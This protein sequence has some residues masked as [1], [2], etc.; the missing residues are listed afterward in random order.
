MRDIRRFVPFLLVPLGLLAVS[1]LLQGGSPAFAEDKPT[2]PAAD[3][4]MGEDAPVAADPDDEE[5]DA[6]PAL[7]E[8]VKIAIKKGVQWLKNNQMSD[9]GWG[10]IEGTHAYGGGKNTNAYKHPAGAAALALYTLLKCKVPMDDPVIR[11]GFKFLKDKYPKPGS[12]YE[13]SMMLLAVTAT[14]DPFKRFSASTAS[15]EAQKVKLTGEW[16]AWATSLKD[17]LLTKRK[18]RQGW[19]YNVEQSGKGSASS[20]PGGDQDLSSTQLA[21]LALLAAERCNVKVDSKVW[22][23]IADFSIKQQQDDGPEWERAVYDRKSQA[24][25]K[26]DPTSGGGDYAKPKPGDAKSPK[27]RARGFAYIKSDK[28]EPDEGQATGGMTACGVGNIQMCRYIL[29]KRKEVA[30]EPKDADALQRV[31]DGCAWLDQNWSPASNPGKKKENVYHIYYM[32]CV[33]RAFDLI[34]NQR[35]GGHMWYVEMA[36]QLCGMQRDKGFWNS[37]STHK[38]EEVLDT[39]FALLVLKQ[40][41]RGGIP[42]GSVTNPGDEPPADNRGK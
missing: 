9:G 34:G 4:A 10:N 37:D 21:T 14:A 23:D 22:M 39:C 29:M 38:P 15:A 30:W 16:L 35:L 42:Y 36:E 32:Y 19:R 17:H 33:E 28:L 12:S 5:S 31:Y 2:P 26:D 20:T 18:G 41:T 27:D 6:P 7:N 3:P 1:M 25:K 40:A 13:T 11:R 8:R 24:S